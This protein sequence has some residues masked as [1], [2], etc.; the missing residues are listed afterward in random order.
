MDR[1]RRR[2][3]CDGAGHGGGR[4]GGHRRL[5]GR[6]HHPVQ[7]R[8]QRGVDLELD[9]A[10][11]ADAA[12]GAVAVRVLHVDPER[13]WGGG[14]V[15]VMVLLGELGRPGHA[16]RVAAHPDG[17]LAR[18]ATA[19]GVPVIPLAVANHVDIGAALRLRRALGDAEV[20]HFH[21]ARAHALA[22]LCRRAGVRL[23]V[24][25]RMDYVPAGGPYVRFLY[26]RAVD[27][28]V[29]ISEG[30]RE[31]LVRVG[32]RRGR[33]GVGPSGI[34]PAAGVAPA[35]ARAALRREW[36][37]GDDAVLVLVVG[38]LE[39]RKGHAVLLD[40]ARRLSPAALG[41]RY[42][43]CGDGSEA[44]ALVEAAAPLGG[45]VCFAGFR[46]DVAACLAAA[47]VVVLP[48]L[49][50][51]LGVAAL[52]AMAASRPLA[53]SRVGGLAEVVVHEETGL[54]VPPGDPL[55]AALRARG[56]DTAGV[57]VSRA[58]PTTQKT[59][60]IAHHQQVVRLDRESGTGP[61]GAGARRVRD[62]V[63]RQHARYDVLVVS[64]YG[65]GAVGADLLGA[66]AEACGQRPFTWVLDPKQANF[67][68]YRRASL[69]KP[70][71]EEA[72]AASGIDIHDAATLREAGARLLERWEA[73]AVL[74][75][76]GEEGMALFKRGP[77]GVVVEEFRTAAREVFDVTGAGDTVLAACALALG[78]GGTLEEATVLANHAAGVVVGKIGTA[79]VSAD[80]L[81]REVRR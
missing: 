32:V 19:A 10:G 38:A 79:T 61:D 65:K 67:A 13:G 6:R 47:D 29:A 7:L 60:I 22:P 18:A 5:P 36:E 66:L 73:G 51:G 72:A 44:G 62:F 59:R 52:E 27:A 4:L 15:Q 33:I 24:T 48:S 16:S 56:A 26:N 50:E 43:F 53:A 41:L 70:N 49:R 30:V 71:R 45:A 77:Q 12:H 78:A 74:I 40:A 76:R 46:R 11:G 37:V 58:G 28:V 42:V 54:L 14:E 17:P 23:V 39:R 34:G 57:V 21:T 2:A 75:S 64:D 80:E 55:I 68:H 20:V 9:G 63:L 8:R 25:R 81:A 1:D 35:G 3:G 31:A 69:V